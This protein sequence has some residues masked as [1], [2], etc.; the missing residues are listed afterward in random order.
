[1]KQFYAKMVGAIAATAAVLVPA[2][3]HAQATWPDKPVR[4]I[5]PFSPRGGTDITARQ[6]G[7]WIEP[8]LG[9]TLVVDNRPGAGGTVG[10]TI[11]SQAEPDGYT[12]LIASASFATAPAM[13][14]R[15]N[16]DPAALTG[17]YLLAKQPHLLVTPPKLPASDL[18]SLVAHVKKNKGEL[19]YAS[20]GNG[21]SIHLSTELLKL[22]TGM[23][24]V[25]VPYRGSGPAII[26]VVAGRAQV[27]FGTMPSLVPQ[28]RDGRLK[29]IAVSSEKRAP[30]LPNVPTIGESGVPGFTYYAWYGL[31]A[32]RGTPQPIQE[33]MNAVLRE[34]SADPANQQKLIAQGLEPWVGSP[35]EFQAFVD[36]EIARWKEVVAE[37]RIKKIN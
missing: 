1:M 5:I 21:S 15:L 33:R 27:L 6:F 34:V 36:K 19:N 32:P 28:V 35:G 24:I 2:A 13:Y 4:V 10:A 11:A 30:A 29:A 37:S 23:N 20:S 7:I 8:K 18:Q 16:Y 17:V 25:H 14:T 9:Q 12:F 26:D 31:F 22:A 3:A